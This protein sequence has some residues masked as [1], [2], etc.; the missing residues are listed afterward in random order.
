MI[1][2]CLKAWISDQR[3]MWLRTFIRWNCHFVV[4]VRYSEKIINCGSG[5]CVENYGKLCRNW[6]FRQGREK[7]RQQTQ[8]N[9]WMTSAE[10]QVAEVK[11]SGEQVAIGKEE[12]ER[13]RRWKWNE[14]NGEWNCWQWAIIRVSF[15]RSSINHNG[16]EAEGGRW[17]A[18]V[19]CSRVITFLVEELR[20]LIQLILL[21]PWFDIDASTV[22]HIE[23]IPQTNHQFRQRCRECATQNN[24]HGNFEAT[25]NHARVESMPK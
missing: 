16:I 22:C 3:L 17:S 9:R 23:I 6:I 25:Q 12:R 7:Q 10:L 13:E 21:Q 4:V 20:V 15:I 11:R 8:Q 19:N 24:D 14:N 2:D 1:N 5:K 18:P